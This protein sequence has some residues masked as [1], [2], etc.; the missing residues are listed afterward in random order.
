MYDSLQCSFLNIKKPKKQSTCP[1]CSG[2]PNATILT[3]EDSDKDLELARGPASCA[4]NMPS[5][6]EDRYQITCTEYNNLRKNQ[7]PHILLDVRV[8]EQYDLCALD[9][10][11]NVPLEKLQE[12]ID[13]IEEM[14]NNW[15]TPIFCICRRGIASV[16]ATKILKDVLASKRQGNGDTSDVPIVKNIK[17]GLNSWREHVDETFPKY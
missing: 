11:I 14:S 4:M 5:Q 3:M 17:G 7:Q 2:P 10:A 1:V 12:S 8:N 9:N 16:E 13:Q 15:N 6:L